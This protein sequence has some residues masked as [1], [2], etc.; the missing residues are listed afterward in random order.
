MS[1]EP[2]ELSDIV[3]G[4]TANFDVTADGQRFLVTLPPGS[5]DAGESAP[6]TPRINVVLNWFEELKQR[7][8]R[9]G[10]SG[11]GRNRTCDFHR[12]A[13]RA[14]YR[15]ATRLRRMPTPCTSTSTTSPGC[16][17]AVD[18]GVPV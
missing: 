10:G 2:L 11:R 16:I 12:A 9:R 4:S 18:P 15:R 3:M 13:D 17:A 5:G 8:C 1:P 6:A 7:V 14:F